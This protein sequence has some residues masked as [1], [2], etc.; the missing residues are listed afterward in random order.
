MVNIDLFLR[1][2]TQSIMLQKSYVFALIVHFFIFSQAYAEDLSEFWSD[3]I[4]ATLPR[5]TRSNA[6][7][8][9]EAE[10]KDHPSE[11]ALF[12]RAAGQY[13]PADT[14]SEFPQGE[15][16]LLVRLRILISGTDYGRWSELPDFDDLVKGL[17]ALDDKRVLQLAQD[18]SEKGSQDDSDQKRLGLGWSQ[19]IFVLGQVAAKDPRWQVMDST[20]LRWSIRSWD[21]CYK[22]ESSPDKR[23]IRK[24]SNRHCILPPATWPID[25]IDGPLS[26]IAI[27]RMT[28]GAD[29][30]KRILAKVECS[31]PMR[32]LATFVQ[33][34]TPSS[35]T[36]SSIEI[37]RQFQG[38][39]YSFGLALRGKSFLERIANQEHLR[40]DFRTPALS[41]V[42]PDTWKR[43]EKN[44]WT[45]SNWTQAVQFIQYGITTS[46]AADAQGFLRRLGLVAGVVPQDLQTSINGK[47]RSLL[48]EAL[49]GINESQ[50]AVPWTNPSASMPVLLSVL[51]LNGAVRFRAGRVLEA[52]ETQWGSASNFNDEQRQRLILLLTTAIGNRFLHVHGSESSWATS[53]QKN[54]IE[55]H[56][57]QESKLK[58]EQFERDPIFVL[59]KYTNHNGPPLGNMRKSINNCCLDVPYNDPLAGKLLVRIWRQI[60]LQECPDQLVSAFTLAA[61]KN[62]INN[63]SDQFEPSTT[64]AEQSK[65]HRQSAFAAACAGAWLCK[66]RD[67]RTPS[68][69]EIDQ[70]LARIDTWIASL[71]PDDPWRFEALA[72]RQDC[73]WKFGRAEA[74]PALLD[75]ALNR[76]ASE[77][78]EMH[79]VVYRQLALATTP[80]AL[81]KLTEQR[82]QKLITMDHIVTYNSTPGQPMFPVEDATAFLQAQLLRVAIGAN[83]R[84]GVL[85]ILES[86][87][88]KNPTAVALL[89]GYDT[90]LASQILSENYASFSVQWCSF[91]IIGAPAQSVLETWAH[92]LPTDLRPLGELISVA[93]YRKAQWFH[94]SGQKEYR[95]YDRD[96]MQNLAAWW[97]T[98]GEVPGTTADQAK[99]IAEKL[100]PKSYV[101]SFPPPKPPKTIPPKTP[102]SPTPQKPSVPSPP[103][104]KIETS[105]ADDF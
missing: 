33:N 105:G 58:P 9:S 31:D 72:W 80:E 27:K 93:C 11:V 18:L 96:Q 77:P 70:Q 13:G 88:K 97:R 26:K 19:L 84:S 48:G 54:V 94:L 25:L 95:S 59:E 90:T 81:K 30:A 41:A 34:I 40:F 89:V 44:T 85:H 38:Q 5:S 63:S 73:A 51:Y 66:M 53:I 22:V 102:P 92:A 7:L 69:S 15:K 56:A 8:I 6:E 67:R 100:A 1:D 32:L 99:K 20:L 52:A 82:T 45:E 103:G 28:L 36:T 10:K 42:S 83:D 75:W 62:L 91:D 3:P 35:S 39:V 79:I 60:L 46:Q 50:K 86:G 64:T 57:F 104:K 101:L 2:V 78:G 49:S 74:D 16:A 14:A 21:V 47:R 98:W 65:D 12:L 76:I 24:I 37:P 43:E 61:A 55:K 17:M 87:A 29:L 23:G 68:R 4:N 71:S